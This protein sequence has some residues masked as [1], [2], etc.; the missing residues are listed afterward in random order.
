MRMMIRLMAVL[1][2]LVA[3]CELAERD[4]GPMSA[5]GM[6]ALAPGPAPGSSAA[7][8]TT[9]AASYGPDQPITITWSGLPGNATD[10][11]AYCPA[12]ATV[13][14]CDGWAYTNGATGG[15]LTLPGSLT[16]GRYVARAYVNNTFSKIGESAAFV[17]GGLRHARLISGFVARALDD[18]IPSGTMENGDWHFTGAGWI[19][20]A[21]PVIPGEVFTGFTW[22]ANK[23]NS[24][25]DLHA[26][27]F[28]I[29]STTG[30]LSTL[31]HDQFSQ[32]GET[33]AIVLAAS[34]LSISVP[35]RTTL[36]LG[37]QEGFGTPDGTTSFSDAEITA[38]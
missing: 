20:Y 37:V 4:P 6:Q 8:V 34:G 23:G 7:T 31:G 24:A 14:D 38:Q 13:Y 29:D 33:G 16:P 10:W 5:P 19:A 25:T 28:K 11:V 30:T 9:D 18:R 17:V 21:L 26:E 32:H 36:I 2:V 35:D 3:G 1:G 15:S 27:I 22:W 12:G